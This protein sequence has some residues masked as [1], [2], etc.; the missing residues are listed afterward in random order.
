M[1]V[2][3]AGLNEAKARL[4]AERVDLI[5][6]ILKVSKGDVSM[7]RDTLWFRA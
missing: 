5:V 4:V 7:W 6:G 1:Q 2:E 3:Q